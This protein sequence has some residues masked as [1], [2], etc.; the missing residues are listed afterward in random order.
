MEVRILPAAPVLGSV[1]QSFIH[2]TF[3]QNRKKRSCFICPISIMVLHLFCNQVTAVR[4]C[5]GAPIWSTLIHHRKTGE[6]P[7]VQR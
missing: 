5:H 4:F 3:N 2:L 6:I 1:Q 7:V